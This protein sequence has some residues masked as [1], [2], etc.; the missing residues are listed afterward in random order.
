MHRTQ[1]K[2][3]TEE[4]L[5]VFIQQVMHRIQILSQKKYVL[6]TDSA[7]YKTQTKPKAKEGRTSMLILVEQAIHRTHRNHNQKK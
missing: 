5:L 1:K 4:D 2:T 7:T 3:T 6:F